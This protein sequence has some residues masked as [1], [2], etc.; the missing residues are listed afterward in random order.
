[1]ELGGS[2][3]QPIKDSH[4]QDS[5]AAEIINPVQQ[6]LSLE[7]IILSQKDIFSQKLGERTGQP[8]DFRYQ[9]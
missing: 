1:M 8:R 4:G 3:G 6:Q 2:L 5:Q 7:Q 9:K